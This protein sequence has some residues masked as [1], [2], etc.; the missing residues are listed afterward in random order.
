MLLAHIMVIKYIYLRTTH[1]QC[2]KIVLQANVNSS[3]VIAVMLVGLNWI[4]SVRSCGSE[5]CLLV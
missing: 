4:Q 5:L 1:E 3:A 2:A